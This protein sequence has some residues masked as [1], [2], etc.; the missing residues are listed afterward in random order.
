MKKTIL[1]LMV[2]MGLGVH[3]GQVSL[4][5]ERFALPAVQGS[6]LVC[7]WDETANNWYSAFTSYDQ[8][9]VINFQ[10]PEWGKWYWVGL[11][12]EQAGE[13]V[14]GKWVGHFISE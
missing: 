9:G 13:Y 12:D 5:Q 6:H 1:T 10:V 11:W 8:Q 14:F 7:I 3:A 4:P 2:L